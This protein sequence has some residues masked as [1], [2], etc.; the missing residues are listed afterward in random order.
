MEK[1]TFNIG[2]AFFGN[3]G[4]FLTQLTDVGRL[5]SILFSN[6]IMIAGIV[7]IFLIIIAGIQMISGS[8]DVQKVA[9][10]RQII[11]AAIIGFILII[12]AF[13]IVRLV[14]SS[15]GISILGSSV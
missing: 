15:L 13:F 6:A 5:V 10:A 9:Q 8:G 12:A 7:L 1:I 3:A 11:T 14:E 2:T 4:H